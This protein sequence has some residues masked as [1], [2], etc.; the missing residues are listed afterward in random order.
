VLDPAVEPQKRIKDLQSYGAAL[1][2]PSPLER[3][4]T[5]L[6]IQDSVKRDSVAAVARAAIRPDEYDGLFDKLTA[7][8]VLVSVGTKERPIIIHR[9]R[10]AS[11]E[12]AVMRIIQDQLDR[13]QPRRSLPRNTLNTAC[14]AIAQGALL[15]A[16]FAHLLKQKELVQVGN[17]L[18][19]ANAQVK[20]TKQQKRNREHILESIDQGQLAPP[21]AKELGKQLGQEVANIET[22]LNLCEE[23]G[24]LVRVGPGMFYS[25]AALEQ[26]RTICAATLEDVSEATLSQLREAWGVS[27]KFAVPMCEYFDQLRVTIRKDDVRIPGPNIGTPLNAE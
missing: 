24:L 7:D 17:N 21:T 16:V 1:G 13:H 27:R 22:L 3:L 15:D 23:D 11:V 19:P 6:A 8:G 25:P 20:L 2:N 10:L 4:S 9:D 5:V 14:R 26:A 18:G 12:K